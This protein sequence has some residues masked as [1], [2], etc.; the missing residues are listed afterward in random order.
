MTHPLLIELGIAGRLSPAQ[1]QTLSVTL[2]NLQDKVSMQ[3]G[4][5]HRLTSDTTLLLLAN[6]DN[7]TRLKNHINRLER[8]L[9]EAGVSYP[10]S[11]VVSEL[12]RG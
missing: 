1:D 2:Q 10:S 11:P 8:R 4:E 9:E 7:I 5:I 12:K 3:L 6:T